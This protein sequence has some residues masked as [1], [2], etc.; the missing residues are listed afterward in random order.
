MPVINAHIWV[1]FISWVWCLQRNVNGLDHL[2]G[3]PQ[4]NLRSNYKR[5]HKTRWGMTELKSLSHR[6][7]CGRQPAVPQPVRPC[8]LPLQLYWGEMTSCAGYGLNI[9]NSLSEMKRLCT[10]AWSGKQEHEH[11]SFL[12]QH[13][14]PA[15]AVG[16]PR[17]WPARSQFH[18]PAFILI[19]GQIYNTCK[20]QLEGILCWQQSMGINSNNE[21]GKVQ[22]RNDLCACFMV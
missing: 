22:G 15:E 5:V 20:K 13:G 1:P 4:I 6:L 2:N 21:M 11:V 18:V 16:K 3:N 10:A 8:I 9:K 7:S 12:F 17:K 19:G 14:T